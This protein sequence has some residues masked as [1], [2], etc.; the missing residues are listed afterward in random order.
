MIISAQIFPISV[1]IIKDVI[2]IY[3]SILNQNVKTK[4]ANKAGTARSKWPPFGF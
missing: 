3:L 4:M 1:Q 2:V